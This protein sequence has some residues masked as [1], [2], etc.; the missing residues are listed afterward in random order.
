MC[1][2]HSVSFI[3]FLRK[4]GM[5]GEICVRILCNQNELLNLKDQ[6]LG[7]ILSVDKT[8]FLRPGHI[9]TY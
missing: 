9:Y 5:Y 2:R 1:Y 3:A 4:F 7:Q 8:Y 6:N